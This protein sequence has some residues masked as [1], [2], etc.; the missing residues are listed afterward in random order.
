MDDEASLRALENSINEESIAIV[1]RRRRRS[2]NTRRHPDNRGSGRREDEAEIPRMSSHQ[3]HRSFRDE[4]GPT[5]RLSRQSSQ[6]L[7]PPSPRRSPQQIYRS[8]S[9]RPS[10]LLSQSSLN[11]SSSQN[12]NP[13]SDQSS[14][15]ASHQVRQ[16]TPQLGQQQ[17]RQK[18]QS[19]RRGSSVD[20]AS[21]PSSPHVSVLPAAES[22][23]TNKTSGYF[24]KRVRDDG[25]GIRV[26]SSEWPKE[27]VDSADPA[28]LLELDDQFNSE[29]DRRARPVSDKING[30]R[31]N[32]P[33]EGHN[34]KQK[35][36]SKTQPRTGTQP[37]AKD[38]NLQSGVN[39]SRWRPLPPFDMS[40]REGRKKQG[41]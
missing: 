37:A 36:P 34:F 24:G 2:T 23:V 6:H 9:L 1:P 33:K 28:T 20:V 29:K 16:P 5:P 7:S 31:E 41:K 11:H 17:Y 21:V 3:E 40:D 26:E 13:K 15:K 27:V 14:Q 39:D 18:S 32:P 12:L 22:C 30:S 38:N 35:S 4:I 19:P 10:P 8:P 25:K